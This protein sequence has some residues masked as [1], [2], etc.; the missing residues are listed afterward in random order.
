MSVLTLDFDLIARKMRRELDSAVARIAAGWQVDIHHTDDIQMVIVVWATCEVILEGISPKE[1]E[2]VEQFRAL[3]REAH[4]LEAKFWKAFK[5]QR[6]ET[7]A[8][9]VNVEIAPQP[10]NAP[11]SN[12]KPSPLKG[13]PRHSH[14]VE[15]IVAI[16]RDLL[17]YVN[18]SLP[19]DIAKTIAE[20][21]GVSR[22]YVYNI[23]SGKSRV[24]VNVEDYTK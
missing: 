2:R 16:K 3:A 19:D 12:A 13:Q 17:P 9:S 6:P 11:A 5:L 10:R 24:D 22:S 4:E 18:K 7:A 21:R 20:L 8:A 15:T 14:T 1:I 23:H